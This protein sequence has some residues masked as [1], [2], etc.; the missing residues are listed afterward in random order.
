[1]EGRGGE[2]GVAGRLRST[3]C[4]LFA[5]VGE[6]LGPVLVRFGEGQRR[7]PLDGVDVDVDGEGDLYREGTSLVRRRVVV[8]GT[9]FFS[10]GTN[11]GLRDSTVVC[12][13]NVS[14]DLHTSIHTNHP[15]SHNTTLTKPMIFINR[16]EPPIA[17]DSFALLHKRDD[18]PGK[19]RSFFFS[20]KS[21]N[22]MCNGKSEMQKQLGMGRK[23]RKKRIKTPGKKK[24]AKSIHLYRDTDL[25]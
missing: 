6:E 12:F 22:K 14:S 13:R 8:A 11:G 5:V 19:R 4:D 10:A 23:E 21:A 25:I 18:F 16:L 20:N 7:D 9:L 1:M 3:D 24:K 15:R 17:S 2:G